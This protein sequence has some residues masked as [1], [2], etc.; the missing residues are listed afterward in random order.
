ML[1]TDQVAFN[2]FENGDCKLRMEPLWISKRER[3]GRQ[4]QNGLQNLL[5]WRE[6]MEY[7]VHWQH[8][9]NDVPS[10]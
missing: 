5:C 8:E 6:G 7:A 9:Y 1:T 3:A 4:E 10:K 2:Q